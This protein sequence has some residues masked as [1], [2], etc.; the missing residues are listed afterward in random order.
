[1]KRVLIAAA[2][3]IVIGISGFFL[4]KYVMTYLVMEKGGRINPE[5]VDH[6]GQML[7][8]DFTYVDNP[9]LLDIIAGEWESKDG[10]YSMTLCDDYS[11]TLV[12]NGLTVLKGQ[13]DFT[14]LQPGKVETVEF[15]LNDY[16]LKDNE[17]AEV[18]EIRSFYYE[19]GEKSGTFHMQIA[20]EDDK[21]SKVEFVKKGEE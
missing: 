10:Q 2:V 1:M 6:S 4:Y 21:N 12:W 16:I 19:F 20:G 8:G 18:G 5:Y 7:D 15:C 9:V 17:D 14:Y 3:L 13:M 11:M